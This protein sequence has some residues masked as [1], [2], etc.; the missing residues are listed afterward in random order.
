MQAGL[1]GSGEAPLAS[2]RRLAQASGG[3]VGDGVA[4]GAGGGVAGKRW[5]AWSTARST[6]RRNTG[7]AT[8]AASISRARATIANPTRCAA[9]PRLIGVGWSI[10]APGAGKRPARMIRVAFTRQYTA[11]ITEITT[12]TITTGTITRCTATNAPRGSSAD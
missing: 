6:R 3:G 10:R 12:P 9:A 11:A 1:A 5:S 4:A 7:I 2:A 8:D